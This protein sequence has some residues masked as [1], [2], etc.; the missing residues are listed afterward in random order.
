METSGPLVSVTRTAHELS[1]IVS[2]A[3]VPSGQENL[4]AE[5]GWRVFVVD[6]PL[7][8][9]VVGVIAGITAPLA[10]AGVPVF[11]VSTFDTDYLLVKETN[12]AWAMETLR[13]AHFVVASD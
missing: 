12:L 3:L 4:H 13:S 9:D 1:L 6:G 11:V 2:E 8:S 7:P 10:Q 5:T